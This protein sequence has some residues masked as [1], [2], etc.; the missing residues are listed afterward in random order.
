MEVLTL[1]RY[2]LEMSLMEYE[3][4]DENDSQMAA[5]AMLLAI[6]MSEN[7]DTKWVIY[8]CHSIYLND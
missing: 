2:I 4:I 6:K 1:A 3:L 8:L 7:V 5:A